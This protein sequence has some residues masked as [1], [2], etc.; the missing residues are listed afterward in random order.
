MEYGQL[1]TISESNSGITK[2]TDFAYLKEEDTYARLLRFATMGN[3]SNV[4]STSNNHKSLDLI[5][6]VPTKF[7]LGTMRRLRRSKQDLYSL[8]QSYQ[9]VTMS[10]MA[11][12][13]VVEAKC[14]RKLGPWTGASTNIHYLQDDGT[15]AILTN[16]SALVQ[17]VHGPSEVSTPDDVL[18][19][20]FFPPVW[21]SSPE[22]GSTSL[23]GVFLTWYLGENN[24]AISSLEWLVTEG[25]I[26]DLDLERNLIVEVC[27][28]SAYWTIGEERATSSEKPNGKLMQTELLSTMERHNAVPIT[29]DPTCI[30]ASQS[31]ELRRAVNHPSSLSLP[32]AFA[33]AISEYPAYYDSVDFYDPPGGDT[34]DA[35]AFTFITTLYGYGYGTTSVSVKLSFATILVYCIV[36]IL[37]IIYTLITGSTSTAWSSA[38]ELVALALQSER[39]DHLR[40]TSVGIDSLKT[41]K[42]GVG[43]RINKD[44]AL[45][46]VFES[47][48]DTRHMR[49]IEKNKAY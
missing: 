5:A 22:V 25:T 27:T 16:L 6:T 31:M 36:T 41:F 13:P 18:P 42:Q 12:H 43:I 29:L 2:N 37:Y 1:G 7:S 38:V 48:A 26:R 24:P 28:V 45:E 30:T 11:A 46:L 47:D 35:F 8:W 40:H 39:S 14:T 20:Q 15:S 34:S 3:G 32:A 19:M 21:L 33:L 17:D 4:G 23:I 10:M 49:K 9:N 44:D